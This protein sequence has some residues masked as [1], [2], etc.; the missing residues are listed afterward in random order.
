M[1]ENNIFTYY[2]NY[3]SFIFI[4]SCF[5]DLSMLCAKYQSSDIAGSQEEDI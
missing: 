4:D 3:A 2:L 1:F 5:Q